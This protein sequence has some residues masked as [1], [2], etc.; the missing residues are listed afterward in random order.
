MVCQCIGILITFSICVFLSAVQARKWNDTGKGA[1]I[2]EESWAIPDII[3]TTNNLVLP[4]GLTLAQLQADLLD[5]HNQRL[6]AMDASGIDFMVLSCITPCVQGISDPAAAAALATK[7]NNEMAAAISNNTMRFGGFASLSMHDPAAAAQELNR[8]VV[9]FG[10][11]GAL[12]NDYQQ[13][14]PDNATLLYYDQPAYD[15]FWSMA[16][17][18]DVPVYLHPRIPIPQ[19]TALEYAHSPFLIAA[20]QEFAVTLSNH[21]MGI[22]ANGVFDR[23]PRLKFI[24]GHLGERIPSD[25]GRIDKKD[26]RHAHAEK[27]IRLLEV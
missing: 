24:V 11:L 7:I 5:I 12:L 20:P 22:T 3:A 17:T 1:I 25:L 9:E 26:P 21:I 19:I 8:T 15:V 23:F 2:L 14:G 16:Q 27:R 10:F 4:A 6:A 18:L 13:S